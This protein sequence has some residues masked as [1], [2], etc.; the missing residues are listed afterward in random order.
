M[1]ILAW[2][3]CGV[4]SDTTRN[5]IRRH[6]LDLKPDMVGIIEPMMHFSTQVSSF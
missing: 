1:N 6:C 2:N 3:V 5:M 4:A